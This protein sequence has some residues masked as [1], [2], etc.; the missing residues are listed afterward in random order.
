MFF[1]LQTLGGTTHLFQPK[2]CSREVYIRNGGL[3]SDTEGQRV[4]DKCAMIRQLARVA[5]NLPDSVSQSTSTSI[6]SMYNRL[7]KNCVHITNSKNQE[8]PDSRAPKSTSFDFVGK[9]YF[10]DGNY[11]ISSRKTLFRWFL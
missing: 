10:E 4:R 11:K 2:N 8:E 5:M 9:F 7:S 3:C 6:M 1:F